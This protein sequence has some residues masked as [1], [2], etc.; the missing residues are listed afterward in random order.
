L[1]YSGGLW[2]DTTAA[3][4]VSDTAAMLS[5]YATK[6]Y[7]DTTGRLYARQDF[8]NVETST[9]TWTQTDTLIPEVVTVV[10]VYRNGQILLPSQYTIPTSTSVVIAAT[11][12]KIGENYTV[13]FPRGGG[14]G[15]GGGSG[16]L[17]VSQAARV[18]LFRLTR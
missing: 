2:R 5:N 16:S 10:Q 15:S 4:L 6:E 1:Y 8:T 3:L 9:L 11:S 14:A 13:I 18:S 12:F 7:A 17:Q